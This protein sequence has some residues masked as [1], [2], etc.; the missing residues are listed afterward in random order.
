MVAGFFFGL[1]FVL[2]GAGRIDP[3]A[4]KVGWGFRLIIF[5]GSMLLWPLLAW[6]YLKRVDF[7]PIES[8]AHR[9]A[10]IE[11]HFKGKKP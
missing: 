1:G 3:V 4:Q 6:R 2:R 8:N 11:A 9:L 7:P 10:A 5:P